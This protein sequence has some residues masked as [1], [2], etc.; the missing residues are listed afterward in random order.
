MLDH[1]HD[2][3]VRQRGDVAGAGEV[4]N[5]GD[6]AAHDLPGARL[7]HVGHDPDVLRPRDLSDQ[8]LDR[9]DDFLLDVLARL[10]AWLEGDV[11]LDRTAADFVDYGY[12]GRFGDLL[13]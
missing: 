6:D 8:P 4:R 13:D 11:Y 1:I 2:G 10:Q 12:G 7:R 9:G 3:R 5:A